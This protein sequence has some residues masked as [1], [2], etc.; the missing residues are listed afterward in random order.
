[1]AEVHTLTARI[2]LDEVRRH[3]GSNWKEVDGILEKG[4]GDGKN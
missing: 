3:E 4:E 2:A 1:M